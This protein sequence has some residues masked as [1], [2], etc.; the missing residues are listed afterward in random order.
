MHHSS[1]LKQV[2][3]AVLTL[4]DT[5]NEAE[6]KSGHYIQSTLAKDH[7]I[8]SYKLIPDDAKQLTSILNKWSEDPQIHAIICTGGTGMSKRDIT[9]STISSLVEKEMLGFGEAFRHKSFLDVGARGMLSNAL[10]GVY[11]DTAI[12]ALPGSLNAVTLA[13]EELIIPI[14]PHFVGELHK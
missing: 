8:S 2:S 5:R 9:Y 12:F 10:A 13:L 6:D 4:S 7:I 1:D 11:K 14:L 3:I